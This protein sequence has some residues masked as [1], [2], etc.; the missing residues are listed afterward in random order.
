MFGISL[1]QG[2]ES[3]KNSKVQVQKIFFFPS[4]LNQHHQQTFLSLLRVQYMTFG[5]IF[6]NLFFCLLF[7]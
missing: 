4:E 7:R 5:Q 6:I 1:H 2:Q 3:K